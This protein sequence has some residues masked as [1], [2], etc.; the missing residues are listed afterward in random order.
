MLKK[1]NTDPGVSAA[2]AAV[3]IVERSETIKTRRA[4]PGAAV[5]SCMTHSSGSI[6]KPGISQVAGS[7]AGDCSGQIRA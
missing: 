3:E 6:S 2:A 1:K 5:K 7:S 4:A